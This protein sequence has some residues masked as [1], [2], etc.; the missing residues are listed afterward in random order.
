MVQK[1]FKFRICGI[2]CI[3]RCKQNGEEIPASAIPSSTEPHTR[4]VMNTCIPMQRR[5]KRR[6]SS[7]STGKWPRGDHVESDDRG[8][9]SHHSNE[10]TIDY[11]HSKDGEGGS[12]DDMG[13][14][15]N[16]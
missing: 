13:E 3:F 16:I 7:S 12:H 4:E 14:L 11:E 6:K 8:H 5:K 9:D 1:T 10:R 2:K 15:H